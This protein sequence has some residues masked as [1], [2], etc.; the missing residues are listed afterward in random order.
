[1]TPCNIAGMAYIN[2]LQAVALT[3][4]NTCQNCEAFLEAAEQYGILGIC[5]MELTTAEEVHVVCLFPTLTDAMDFDA[6]VRSRQLP[7]P[8]QI[9]I[10]G[11]QLLYGCE[12]QPLGE[13]EN[14]LISATDITFSELPGLVRQYH[15]IHIP[16]H[17]ERTSDSLLSNLGFI[18]QDAQFQIYE[19]NHPEKTEE[20]RSAHSYLDDCFCITDSDAHYLPDIKDGTSCEPMEIDA[21]SFE[22]IF[23]R[24]L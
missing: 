12:D 22:G 11:N 20:I 7:I 23:G 3:D 8:N 4:H 17:L 18:P 14:L 24:F 6:C 16:A 13:F 9:P 19:I 1:M 5:G 2:G 15:G 21:L 10:F